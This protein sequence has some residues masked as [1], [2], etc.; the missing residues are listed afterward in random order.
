MRGLTGEYVVSLILQTPK[1]GSLTWTQ[2]V[3]HVPAPGAGGARLHAYLP[4][5]WLMN[6]A[7]GMVIAAALAGQREF[8]AESELSF[9][10]RARD[11]GFIP[12]RRAM[13]RC[14]GA[15]APDW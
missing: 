3:L 9:R 14:W 1:P 4:P 2:K 8:E 5:A 15:S 12:G 13:R 10:L 11:I 6:N 7:I